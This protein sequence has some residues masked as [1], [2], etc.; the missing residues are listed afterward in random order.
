[1]GN[2]GIQIQVDYLPNQK[3]K[4]WIIRRRVCRRHSNRSTSSQTRLPLRR[5]GRTKSH[6]RRRKEAL[7]FPSYPYGPCQQ[8]IGWWKSQARK[9]SRRGC[10]TSCPKKEIN[11]IC[12]KA[13]KKKIDWGEK[14]KK[15]KKKKKKS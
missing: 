13:K 6:Y 10:Q 1:M 7:C 2:Q 12:G 5:N 3:R 8:E 4:G 14:K 9:R 11:L 15:K